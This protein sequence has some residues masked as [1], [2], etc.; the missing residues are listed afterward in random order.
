MKRKENVYLTC[1]ECSS[2][3]I[4]AYEETAWKLLVNGDFEHYCQ[5]VKLHDAEAESCCL[6]CDWTGSRSNLVEWKDERI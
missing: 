1:P 2:V 3:E 6:D 5:S 4:L